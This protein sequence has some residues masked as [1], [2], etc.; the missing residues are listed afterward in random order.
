MLPYNAHR[1][2]KEIVLVN[3]ASNTV[4]KPKDSTVAK[5]IAALKRAGHQFRSGLTST[6]GIAKP[7]SASAAGP[8][9]SES[10]AQP[11][12]PKPLRWSS[13]KEAKKEV[14]MRK[15]GSKRG[16]SA[17]GQPTP[18]PKKRAS[19]LFARMSPKKR[20]SLQVSKPHHRREGS[21]MLG[22]ASP[23]SPW[24]SALSGQG[25]LP[26]LPEDEGT[27]LL[28]GGKRNIFSTASSEQALA[29]MTVTPP[30]P[31][32]REAGTSLP[33]SPMEA[34]PPHDMQA[35][36]LRMD[37]KGKGKALLEDANVNVS[38]PGHQRDARDSLG[39][40]V[41]S[42][43]SE[44]EV[45][46]MREYFNAWRMRAAQA[47]AQRVHAPIGELP[48]EE[49]APHLLT[50]TFTRWMLCQASFRT[51]RLDYHCRRNALAYP[52]NKKCSACY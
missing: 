45:A 2:P 48:P 10:A 39:A 41:P 29:D 33:A 28:R 34:S 14:E 38:A 27:P 24:E 5:Y 20:P 22:P 35:T 25:R 26:I 6:L 18:E 11:A 12:S 4:R 13:R 52:E 23:A 51:G 9:M 50:M 42:P 19:S 30:T 8:S 31:S 46:L 40:A 16:S 3:L 47:H 44:R 7:P 1:L 21:G 43:D 49:S 36:V 17:Q 15:M 37:V 32:P